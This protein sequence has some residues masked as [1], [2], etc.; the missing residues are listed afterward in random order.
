VFRVSIHLRQ[1]R[2]EEEP[3][4]SFCDKGLLISEP[5]YMIMRVSGYGQHGSY[6]LKL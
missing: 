5:I 6:V 4:Q 2:Q 3:I 1:S